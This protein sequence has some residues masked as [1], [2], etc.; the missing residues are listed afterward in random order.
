M[1]MILYAL[2]AWHHLVDNGQTV[3]TALSKCLSHYMEELAEYD[4]H[5]QYK[6]SRKNDVANACSYC[7]D[8]LLTKADTSETIPDWPYFYHQYFKKE[9]IESISPA[10][11]HL[12]EKHE[13]SFWYDDDLDIVFH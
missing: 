7:P 6:P 12:L 11:L 3:E 8:L 5:I 4:V 10:I 2:C 1:L 13:S 9:D